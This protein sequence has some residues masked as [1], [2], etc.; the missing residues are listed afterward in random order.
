MGEIADKFCNNI[1]ITDDN[2]RNE[3]PRLIRKEIIKGI[4]SKN[5]F[6]ISDRKIAIR[7]AI[8]NLNS[9]EILLVAG[10][11]HETTQIY[12]KKTK[13][14]SDRDIITRSIKTKNKDLSKN[15]KLNIIKEVSRQK[16]LL[17]N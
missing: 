5:I 11:G 12:K 8:L 9:S 15:V 17:R 7:N 10:K 3:N 14:F 13:F 16:Y 1:Y 4:K 6:E 2:P